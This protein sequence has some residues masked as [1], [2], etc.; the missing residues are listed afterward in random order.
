MDLFEAIHTRRSVRSYRPD[1]VG[2]EVLEKIV[3]CGVEAPSG[4][5]M[6]L[7]QYVI[8]DDPALMEQLYPVSSALSGA[9]AGIV[10]LIEPR[11]N[12]FGEFYVQDASAAIENML[13][14]AVALGLSACWVEGAVRRHEEALRKLLAVPDPYRVWAILPIGRAAVSPVRPP[15][16]AAK[17]VTH[18]NRF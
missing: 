2:R 16:P 14:A 11:G 15:K 1:P 5:N 18:Y 9:P 10:L 12:K 3:A 4:C 13:L 17:D 7:R 8:V 6:Q